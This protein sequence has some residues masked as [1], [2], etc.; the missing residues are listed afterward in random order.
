VASGWG[1]MPVSWELAEGVLEFHPD[2]PERQFRVLLVVAFAAPLRTRVGSPGMPRITHQAHCSRSTAKRALHAL[3]DRGLLK[4]TGG[5]S[6]PGR[7]AEYV[8]LVQPANGVHPG[9]S[10]DGPNAVHPGVD[11]DTVPAG[12]TA[13]GSTGAAPTGSRSARTGST[14]GDR[15][16]VHPGA[17]PLPSTDI[18]PS[19]A[20]AGARADPDAQ[21]DWRRGPARPGRPERPAPVRAGDRAPNARD[22]CPRGC[23]KAH[24]TG[25]CP[26]DATG[27]P[28]PGGRSPGGYPTGPMPWAGPRA[29]PHA[30]VA[31]RGA[32]LAQ[33]AMAERAR[34]ADAEPPAPR[35]DDERRALARRQAAAARADRPGPAADAEPEPPAEP[36]DLQPPPD[37]EPPAEEPPT[38][39]PPEPAPEPDWLPDEDPW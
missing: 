13:T 36:W 18:L 2:L 16:G 6:G 32:A 38:T 12:S 23:G 22:L 5:A 8:V 28:S 4:P 9:V 39:D 10:P 14:Q 33:Q 35:T 19:R 24:G 21:P 25:P 26:L 34:P 11:P 37:P 17:D 27:P 3:T 29:N 7:N 1:L 15:Y 20:G 30:D 31:H